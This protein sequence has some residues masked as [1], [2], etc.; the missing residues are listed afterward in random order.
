LGVPPHHVADYLGLIGDSSDNVLGVKGI[1]PKT[2]IQLI[3]QFGSVDEILANAEAVT[4]KRAR[5]S[6]L[7]FADEARL[8]KTLVTIRTDLDVPLDLD[9]LQCGASDRERLKEIFI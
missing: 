7:Q 9:R 4:S 3:E 1:G 5:E 6:L 8:S 2:A